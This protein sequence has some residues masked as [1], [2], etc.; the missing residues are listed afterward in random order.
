[1]PIEIARAA[2]LMAANNA[3]DAEKKS[4]GVS[5]HGE[6]EPTYNWRLFTE[7]V[8]FAETLATERGID[9]NFSMSTNA[10]WGQKQCDFIGQHFKNLSISL[11]GLPDIQDDQR[12]T[13]SGKGSF[14]MIR[15]SLVTLEEMNVDYGFRATVLPNGIE[16]IPGF[17]EWMAAETKAIGLSV[18]PVFE[19]GRASEM[20]INHEAFYQRFGELFI[21]LQAQ[22]SD[23]DLSLTYSGCRTQIATGHFCQATGPDPNFTVMSDGTVSSCYEINDENSPKGQFAVFGRWSPDENNFILDTDRLDRIRH[24]GVWEQP[25]CSDCFAKWNCGGDC[26]ARSDVAFGGDDTDQPSRCDLNRA[27]TLDEI[28]RL[29][30]AA[31]ISKDPRLSDSPQ[32]F[33]S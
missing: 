14:E 31:D 2:M 15:K 21:Q 23:L 4:F 24:F 12:P 29:A 20:L 19:N 10:L 17:L 33:T 22:A 27:T 13:P 3:K 26:I 25:E 16:A 6:G 5:F 7:C 11:D 8:E 28:V 9:V 1:M 30:V 32:T 18:E